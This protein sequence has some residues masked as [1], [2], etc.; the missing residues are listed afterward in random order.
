[1]SGFC[2]TDIKAATEIGTGTIIGTNENY[3]TWKLEKGVLTVSGKGDMPECTHEKI[4]DSLCEIRKCNIVKKYKRN[5]RN[6][7]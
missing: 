7:L 2:R 5:R 1:M 6:A 4:E 3:I